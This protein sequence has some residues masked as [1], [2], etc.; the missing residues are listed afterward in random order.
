MYHENKQQIHLAIFIICL[1]FS[2]ISHPYNQN[3]V[4]AKA[5]ETNTGKLESWMVET[6]SN[7][8]EINWKEEES[9]RIESE[10]SGLDK[11]IPYSCWI[12]CKIEALTIV[13]IIPEIAESLVTNCKAL[14][15]DP[16]RCIKI[17]AFIVVNESSWGKSC[18]NSNQYNCFGLS[19]KEDYKSYNDWVLHFVGKYNRFW[20]NQTNPNSFYSNSPDWK[21]V[22]RFCMS[23]NSSW[24][25]YCKNWHRIAWSVFNK[26]NKLF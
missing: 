11:V 12:S 5:G 13:W 23:E 10:W 4:Q 24:L 16:I 25:P 18:K 7:T 6:I 22:T 2:L 3:I 19:V 20:L 14:A 1:F 26:L 8:G 21:P 9:W 17:W 15:N